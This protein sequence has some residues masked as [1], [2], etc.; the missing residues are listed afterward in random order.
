MMKE[1]H[2]AIEIFEKV[3]SIDSQNQE[4]KKLIENTNLK[5]NQEMRGMSDEERQKRA[6]ADPQI[7]AIIQDPMVQIAL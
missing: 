6:M 5:I 2:K 7:Q 1:Y 3:I 4:A